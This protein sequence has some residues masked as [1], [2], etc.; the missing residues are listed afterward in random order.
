MKKLWDVMVLTLAINFLAVAGAVGWLYQTHRLTPENIEAVKAI[1]FPPPVVE[2]APTT[3]PA[4]PTTQ[5]ILQLD[6]LLA[7]QSGRSAAQQVEFIQ[8]S[9]DAQMAQLD[10]RH[11]ELLALQGQVEAAK[12]KMAADRAQFEADRQALAAEQEQAD[13]LASDKGFQ[14]SLALYTAMPAKKAKDVFMALDDDAITQYLQAMQPRTAA[15]IIKEFK[16][17]E[18]T[19]R[20]QKVLE[21]MRQQSQEQS[22]EATAAAAA[23]SA[24]A[25]PAAQE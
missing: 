13:R 17:P 1:L 9:F 11:R 3:Q 25:S 8:R 5:P 14:D 22:P 2:E 24:T 21:K 10:R 20:I 16:L 15:K 19:D 4:D 18:E 12:Q 6:E 23:A 7:R